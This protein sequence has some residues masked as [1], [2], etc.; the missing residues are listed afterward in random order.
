M[1]YTGGRACGESRIAGGAYNSVE[2]GEDGGIPIETVLNC[3]PSLIPNIHQLGLSSRGVKVLDLFGTG[4]HHVYDVIG[5]D[6]YPYFPDYFE[7]GYRHGFSRLFQAPG[8]SFPWNLITRDSRHLLIHPRAILA[9]SDQFFAKRLGTGPWDKGCP[10]KVEDHIYPMPDLKMLKKLDLPAPMC[11]SLTWESM[12]PTNA[13]KKT[14]SGREFTR[15]GVGFNFPA[16]IPPQGV[17]PVWMYGIVMWLPIKIEVVNDDQDGT[18]KDILSLLESN[19][20]NV[21]YELVDDTAPPPVES[22][23]GEL[24]WGNEED[25]EAIAVPDWPS[26]Q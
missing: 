5:M 21:A 25:G 17:K 6:S 22:I 26:A 16:S 4:V 7:E 18:H 9:N 11:L 3:P 15:S 19:A 23:P 2:V 10:K 12:V 8:T 1:K 20:T 14:L 24:W 13:E